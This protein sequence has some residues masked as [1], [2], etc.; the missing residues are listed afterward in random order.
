MHTSVSYLKKKSFHRFHAVRAL[1]SAFFTFRAYALA[2]PTRQQ[3]RLDDHDPL[4]CGNDL[5]RHVLLRFCS[6]AWWFV[7]LE[8]AQ[9]LVQHLRSHLACVGLELEPRGAAFVDLCTVAKVFTTPVPQFR[10]RSRQSVVGWR[11][12]F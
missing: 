2:A 6:S 5:P 10:N 4:S 3:P 11:K 1:K 12:Y 7:G 9:L 8:L